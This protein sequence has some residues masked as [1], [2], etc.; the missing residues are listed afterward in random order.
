[1]LVHNINYHIIKNQNHIKSLLFTVIIF[2]IM[3]C[4]NACQNF[5]SITPNDKSNQLK[6]E[7]A[8]SD[9]NE[10]IEYEFNMVKNPTTGQIPLGSYTGELE[11]AKA[12]LSGQQ[13]N[14]IVTAN[15]FIGPVP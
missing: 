12:I 2:S 4:L 10:A 6:S 8:F 1:M 15:P 11:Q 9:F 14:N 7:D 5:T 13:Q 3:I